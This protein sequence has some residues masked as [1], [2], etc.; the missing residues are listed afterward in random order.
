ML[1]RTDSLAL[2]EYE[3][4]I[5]SLLLR[6]GETN[7]QIQ[8]LINIGRKRIINPARIAEI[9]DGSVHA[10]KLAGDLCE[11]VSEEFLYKKQNYDY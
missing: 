5:I 1:K 6:K 7:Q 3:K 4:A 8:Y 10:A 2:T 11:W 9:K